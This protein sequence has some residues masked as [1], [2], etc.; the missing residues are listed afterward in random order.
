VQCST[1]DEKKYLLEDAKKMNIS[2]QMCNHRCEYEDKHS[3]I[4]SFMVCELGI[5]SVGVMRITLKHY[6]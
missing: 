5:G 3:N 6:Q 1:I 2:L 4:S